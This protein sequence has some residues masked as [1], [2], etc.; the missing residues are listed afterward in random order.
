[1]SESVKELEDRVLKEDPDLYCRLIFWT[2]MG[3]YYFRAAD[4]AY[5]NL[6]KLKTYVKALKN[7]YKKVNGNDPYSEIVS[8]I[9]DQLIRMGKTLIDARRVILAGTL[10]A[11]GSFWT[12][13]PRGAESHGQEGPQQNFSS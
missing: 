7:A 10:S 11:L 9:L 8:T 1:V 6:D 12:N 5:L 13:W 4:I 3:I 2:N